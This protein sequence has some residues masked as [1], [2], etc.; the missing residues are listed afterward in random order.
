MNPN[1]PAAPL[2][3]PAVAA[4]LGVAYHRLYSL[5]RYRVV[6]PPAERDSSGHMLWTPAEVAAAR[7]AIAERDTRRR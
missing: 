4:L 1:E 5:L 3:T 6:P 2:K 7:A